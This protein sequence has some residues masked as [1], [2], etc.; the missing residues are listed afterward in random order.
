MRRPLIGGVVSLLL[1]LCACVAPARLPG[2][3]ATPDEPR[4][5]VFFQLLPL[6][7]DDARDPGNREW[8]L[9]VDVETFAVAGE[10]F[11]GHALSR[12][13]VAAALKHPF[14]PVRSSEIT[15]S[16]LAN[17]PAGRAIHL[18]LDS[19]KTI[20]SRVVATIRV[21]Y[22]LRGNDGAISSDSTIYAVVYQRIGSEW[23]LVDRRV[24]LIT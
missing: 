24:L 10:S 15:H 22:M 14:T 9:L 12:A 23:R 5:S 6:L 4:D 3:A 16:W 18:H 20:D 17:V 11:V 13:D 21:L 8:P 7:V 19:L 1:V 2:P